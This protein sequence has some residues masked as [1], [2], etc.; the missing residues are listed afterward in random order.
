MEQFKTSDGC[1]IG[2]RLHSGHRPGAPRVALIHPLGLDGSVWQGVIDALEGRATLL[3]YDC[4]GHGT[5]RKY[6]GPFT[7]ELFARDLAE[8]LDHVGWNCAVVVGCSMGGVVAQA[9]AAGYPD[10]LRALG[11]IDTTAWYGV[12]APRTWRE[13]ASNARANGLNGMTEFQAS[14]WF[15]DK[16]REKHADRVEAVKSIFLANDLP[17]Y[18]ATCEMLGDMDMR[19]ALGTIGVPVA[20]V[21]GDED[22][23]TPVSMSKAL[24]DQIRG[25]TLAV[26]SDSRHLTPVESPREI[27]NQL[28]LLLDRVAEHASA[29]VN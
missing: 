19:P 1:S 2:F 3:T 28:S 25:S 9:F 7:P 24:H 26:L 8:L 22:Y 17:S 14:R 6:P 21:V 12:D 20:I 27:A 5:S 4:R 18:S 29:A 16:F 23:A 10:R 11:L 13:R 15:S